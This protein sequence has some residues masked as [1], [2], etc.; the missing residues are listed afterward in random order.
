MLQRANEAHE[1]IKKLGASELVFAEQFDTLG[2]LYSLSKDQQQALTCFEKAAELDPNNAHYQLNMALIRQ[3][4]GDIGGAES[5][6]DK[7]ISL[8]PDN[9]EAWLHRS[10]LRKQIPS[11]NHTKDMETVLAKGIKAW[12][13]E[14][15]IRYALAKEYEDLG[16]YQSSF[17][18]LK[19]GSSIRR[20][21]MQHDAQSDLDTI[22][23]IIEYFSE[24]YLLR[25][26]SA[27]ENEEPIFIVGF[28]RTGTTLVERILGSHSEVYAAGELNNFAEN[29][30]RQISALD[31]ERP[32]NRQQ[33]VESSTRIDFAQ[34]GE[35]YISSTRP[36]TGNTS[37]FIDKLPLNFL[38]CGLILKAL[39]KAKIIHL[40]R[41]PMDTCFAVYKTLFKQA[42]PFSYDLEELGHYF[43]AYQKLMRHWHQCM[44]GKI[45]DVSYENL[46][47]NQES[48]SRRLVSFCGLAWEDACL[49]FH[50]NS[51]P[52]M[53]ASLAQVRQPVYTTSVGRW[54]NYQE[55]LQV[56][57]ELFKNPKWEIK[58]DS[59]IID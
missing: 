8:D 50:K 35:G 58:A 27:Y 33:Y 31:Q 40:T 20:G 47:V 44:P 29:L 19:S 23:A 34:L 48:E 41:H 28:P 45:L 32:A 6:F 55:E 38:Y 13:G 37:R 21:H 22:D 2:N 1:L 46:T 12:R 51:A 15:A 24:E 57:E 49:E 59:R 7:T 10:R 4:M 16:E 54:R 53:T 52:S 3:A 26:T 18:H 39:P 14:V 9:H 17:Q 30:N 42:Y 43:L 11:N 25:K 5:A 36:H 56:L